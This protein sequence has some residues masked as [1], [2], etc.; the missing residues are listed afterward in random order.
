MGH[1]QGL[2][3]KSEGCN[4]KTIDLIINIFLT[5]RI[6]HEVKIMNEDIQQQTKKKDR[7]AAKVQH[8]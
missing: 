3:L 2:Q 4:C 7:K 5:I 6:H 1:I 8:K